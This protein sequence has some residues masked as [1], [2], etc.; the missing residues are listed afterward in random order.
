MG[1]HRQLGRAPADEGAEAE[2]AVDDRGAGEA[3]RVGDRLVEE[4]LLREAGLR[5]PEATVVGE[6][7]ARRLV[8]GR[9]ER[10]RTS[11]SESGLTTGKPRLQW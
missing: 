8:P 3:V 1:E 5:R 9:T 4:D 11:S 10:S 6:A 2:R 7:G